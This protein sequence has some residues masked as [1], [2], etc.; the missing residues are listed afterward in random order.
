[1]KTLSPKWRGA[2]AALVLS[3]SILASHGATEVTTLG[4]GPN[5]TSNSRSG[6]TDG[7]TLNFAKFSNPFAIAFDANGDL[8]IADKNNGKIRK[9]NHPGSAESVTTTFIS[10]LRSPVGVAIDSSNRVYVV[11]QGDGKLRVFS[12]AGLL[13]QTVSGLRSPT[14]LAL[15]VDGNVFVTEL[16]GNVRAIAPDGTI[17]LVASGFRKPHGIA[18]LRSG[19]L[20]VSETSGNAIYT[21]DPDTGIA[22][23]IA[24]GNGAGFNN[25]SGLAAKFNQPYGLALAP[26][27]ALVV[28]D[29]KNNRVRLISSVGTNNVVSTLFGMSS[30][31]WV[32]PFPGWRDG[33][34]VDESGNPV[35]ATRQPVGVAVNGEGTVFTTEIFYDLL[36]QATGTGLKNLTGNATNV[37]TTGTN[38]VAVVGTNVLSFGFESGEGSSDFIAAA[39][40]HFYA[41]VTIAV[42]PGQKVYS[43]QFG[44]TGTNETAVSFDPFA[45]TFSSMLLQPATL[46]LSTNPFTGEVITNSIEY[47]GIVP[48]Y[49][50]LDSSI[51]LLA[52]G[53]IEQYKHTNLYN[54]LIHHLIQYSQAKDHLFAS[55]DGKAILGA[56]GVA[57]PSS[58]TPADSYRITLSRASAT[59]QDWTQNVPLLLPTDGSL[60]SGALN[61]IKR[62]TLGSRLYTVGD[63]VP[64]R[65]F[66]A[67][68]FGEGDLKNNDVIQVFESAVYGQNFPIDDSDLFNAMDSSDGSSGSISFGDDVTINNI[69][70]WDGLLAV[71]DVWVTFRRSLDP[72][73]KWYAR[74]WSNGALQVVEVTNRLS[75]EFGT[76]AAAPVR[77]S[78]APAQ[79]VSRPTADLSVNDVAASAGATL[80]LP[81][82]LS[83]SGDFPLRVM[84]LNVT[85]EALD[86]SPAITTP[87][88]FRTAPAFHNP[89]LTD[90]HG[91]NNYAAA[92]LDQTI[93]GMSGDSLLAFLTVQVPANAGSRAAYRVHFNHF[94][95]S[96]NGVALFKSHVS[97]GL[98][99]L[100]DRSASTWND[101]ISDA[102]RLRYFGSIYAPESAPGADADGDG[103]INSVEYQNGTDPTDPTS[104]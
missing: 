4:G 76:A 65:W 45:A 93:S 83:L 34:A 26:N 47:T 59:P 100:S 99:L 95:A 70:G 66:N 75:S 79:P 20:A 25:G 16:S 27:G 35:A 101:G 87:I 63:A 5:Q 67:G 92:W 28:A 97:N 57:I 80:D 24:G 54:T 73:L 9:V 51:N 1:M 102:W 8:F 64:F 55:E 39:G 7:G 15:D 2:A 61:S 41:P 71:D 86:G 3:A 81:V 31:G 77:R 10:G 46:I 13:L 11:T 62:I 89:D 21:V 40:Q 60:G 43:L 38:T 23:L 56:Y 78:A 30:A 6:S 48:N 90:S 88:Q 17:T 19:L 12:S 33:P 85:V 37:I 104:N 14:A 18:V 44:I 52:I 58:A 42:A 32:K 36:R 96:P 69:T 22:T 72:T 91:A 68:E 103:V 98:I 94:S 53:W 49:G 29:Y 84:M 82:Q 74:Y 50:F